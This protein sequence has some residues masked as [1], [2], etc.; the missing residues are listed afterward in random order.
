MISYQ[1]NKIKSRAG[2]IALRKVAIDNYLFRNL[3]VGKELPSPK[4]LDD[5]AKS[6]IEFIRK[7]M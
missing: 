7:K 5:S 3:Y 4:S 2:E 1:E 6:N